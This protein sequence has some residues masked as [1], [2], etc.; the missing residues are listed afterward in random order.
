MF[1]S[2]ELLDGS[3]KSIPANALLRIRST[4]F[5]HE[6]ESAV[7]IQYDD[8]KNFSREN[9][10]DLISRFGDYVPLVKLTMLS[11]DPVFV[12]ANRVL[13]VSPPNPVLHNPKAKAIVNFRT[14]SSGSIKQKSVFSSVLEPV[15][16]VE[17]MLNDAL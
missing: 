9:I 17:Q 8:R 13:E 11:S 15:S 5:N 12:S 16:K 3:Q 1:L 14:D 6:P 2:Y 7:M 4:V 10:D